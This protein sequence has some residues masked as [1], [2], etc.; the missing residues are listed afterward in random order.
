MATT[1][2]LTATEATEAYR[3]VCAQYADMG[4]EAHNGFVRQDEQRWPT[5]PVLCRK[6]E[7]WSTLTEWAVVWEGGP[8]DWPQYASAAQFEDGRGGLPDGIF[9]EP[10]NGFALGL[11]PA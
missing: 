8:E 4:V 2:N 11:Y 3:A 9:V 5:G 7:G 6:F 10:V 1:K